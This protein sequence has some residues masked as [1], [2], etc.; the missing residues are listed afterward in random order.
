MY[1]WWMLFQMRPLDDLHAA[2]LG[3]EEPGRGAPEGRQEDGFLRDRLVDLLVEPVAGGLVGL[4]VGLGDQVV[5][6][7]FL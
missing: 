4:G 3:L 7:G 1:I 5:Q 6:V 2:D